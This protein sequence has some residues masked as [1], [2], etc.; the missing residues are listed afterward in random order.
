MRSIMETGMSMREMEAV[1]ST[2]VHQLHQIREG[3]FIEGEANEL[4][5]AVQFPRFKV[6][7]AAVSRDEFLE[8]GKI[9]GVTTGTRT[10][11]P[12]PI[13]SCPRSSRSPNSRPR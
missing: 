5:V 8:R 4:V 3:R 1:Q 13:H 2:A 6:L 10:D 9:Y 7:K 12:S 11:L